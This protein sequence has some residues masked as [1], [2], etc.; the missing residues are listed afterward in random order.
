MR[1]IW[2][3]I[4]WR[5]FLLLRTIS[6]LTWSFTS[7]QLRSKRYFY[8][9]CSTLFLEGRHLQSVHFTP[10]ERFFLNEVLRA[11]ISFFCH[12]LF[13]PL[14]NQNDFIKVIFEG[15]WYFLLCADRNLIDIISIILK[16]AAT[17]PLMW[18]IC[19][20]FFFIII[21]IIQ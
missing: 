2:T 11:S 21:F 4:H 5:N 15:K 10:S 17:Q 6:F 7:F 20:C 13:C 14:C 3:M 18:L 12:G 8:M 9:H 16:N 1:T 19:Y